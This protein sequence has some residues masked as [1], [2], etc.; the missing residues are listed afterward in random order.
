MTYQNK[1]PVVLLH[2]MFG[3]GQQQITNDVLP[4]FGLWTTDVRKMF[5]DMGV[6][7]VAPS[8]GPFTSAW[9]R[10]CEIY[11]QLFGG[12]VTLCFPSGARKMRTATSSKST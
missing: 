7:C 4:Y 1:Y 12:T 9:N 8:M 2:G 10:A 11:A 3:F 6:P 5:I